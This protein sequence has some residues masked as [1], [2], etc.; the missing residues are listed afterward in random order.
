MKSLSPYPVEII[1]GHLTAAK[2]FLM[3]R[4]DLHI[5]VE[6]LSLVKHRMTNPNPRILAAQQ[7]T[8]K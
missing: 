1:A 5:L 4:K 8:N 7:L 3:D 6:V 2:L